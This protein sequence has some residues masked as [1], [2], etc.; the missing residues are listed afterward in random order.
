MF[1]MNPH[2]ATLIMVANSFSRAPVNGL[3]VHCLVCA[4]L[5]LGDLKQAT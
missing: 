3:T 2:N 1:I 5:V 4:L